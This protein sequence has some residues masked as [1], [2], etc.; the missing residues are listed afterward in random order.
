MPGDRIRLDDG[1]R[2]SCTTCGG[3]CA[4]PWLVVATPDERAAIDALAW[5]DRVGPRWEDGPRGSFVIP[6]K[7]GTTA[8]EMLDDDGLCR[9]HKHFGEPAKPLICQRFPYAHVASDEHVF[10]TASFGCKSVRED[11]GAALDTAHAEHLFSKDVGEADPDSGT[12]YPLTADRDLTTAE[13]DAWIDD[14][15]LG[16]DLFE[17]M[18]RLGGVATGP[19]SGEA[20]YAFALTLYGD[21]LDVSSAWERLKGVFRLPRAMEL[22]LVYQSRLLDCE[23]DMAEVMEHPGELPPESHRLLIRWMRSKLV[24][25]AVFKDVPYAMAGITRLLLEVDAALFFSRALA[26]GRAIEHADV[27][28]AVRQTELFI[29]GQRTTLALSRLDPRLPGFWQSDAV[30]AD[31]ARLFTSRSAHPA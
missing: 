25:R 22:S 23:V 28:R 27:L 30:R 19:V 4:N 17:A 14:L 31:A 10:V 20:R 15:A 8:C 5:G 16:D 11:T 21:L 29:A 3:C 18:E 1:V 12:V 2:F 13:F 6:K 9:I 26:R 24:G 7:P